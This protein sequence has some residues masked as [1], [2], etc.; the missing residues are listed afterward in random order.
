MALGMDMVRKKPHHCALKPPHPNTSFDL[1]KIPSLQGYWVRNNIEPMI[2]EE[3]GGNIFF[4]SLNPRP[5]VIF[6]HEN[7]G[8]L[9]GNLEKCDPKR[10]V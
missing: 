5:K 1:T 2:E 6:W 4:Q 10:G 7:N 9:S 3:E 8:L